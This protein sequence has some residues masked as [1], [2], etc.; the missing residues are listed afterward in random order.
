[1]KATKIF[2]EL[3]GDLFTFFHEKYGNNEVY[4]AFQNGSPNRSKVVRLTISDCPQWAS[5]ALILTQYG[6]SSENITL[7]FSASAPK[8]GFNNDFCRG[9]LTV[10]SSLQNTHC[11]WLTPEDSLGGIIRVFEFQE[12]NEVISALR[13]EI[14]TKAHELFYSG[15]YIVKRFHLKEE[16][17]A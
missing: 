7:M 6:E 17:M 4:E 10:H 13:I 2:S 5:P 14:I 15:D 16:A 1:M 3:L 12:G 8:Q 11:L 9:L